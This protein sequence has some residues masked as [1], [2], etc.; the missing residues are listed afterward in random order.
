M[1][2]S[3]SVNELLERSTWNTKACVCPLCGHTKES[4]CEYLTEAAKTKKHLKPC[5][6]CV[7]LGTQYLD[8]VKSR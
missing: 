7:G 5:N 6:C 2:M 4:T 3:Q 1:S 8:L